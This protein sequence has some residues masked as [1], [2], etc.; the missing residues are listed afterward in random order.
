[1][2]YRST[3]CTTTGAGPA[4]I[5]MGRKIRTTLSTLERNLQ[6]ML[7]NKIHIKVKRKQAFYYNERWDLYLLGETLLSKRFHQKEWMPPAVVRGER[8]TRRS[9]II[10]TQNGGT[11]WH[12]RRHLQAVPTPTK[13]T[14]PASLER[15]ESS[16]LPDNAQQKTVSSTSSDTRL[17]W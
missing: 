11:L 13:G 16:L 5:L 1:M 3:P 17:P 10:E 8:T 14:T 2:C 7:P 9:Y 12:N 4:E 6:L 15:R